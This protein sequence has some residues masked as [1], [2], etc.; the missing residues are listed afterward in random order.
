[1]KQRL[2]SPLVLF[3]AAVL[4]ATGARYF[5]CHVTKARHTQEAIAR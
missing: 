4:I 3:L 1:M 5:E 2:K